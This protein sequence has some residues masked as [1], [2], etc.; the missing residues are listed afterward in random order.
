MQQEHADV[1][2]LFSGG[3]DSLLTALLL[4]EQGLAVRCLHGISPFFGDAAA[5]AG[6]QEE[7]GL[8]F[9]AL[10]VGEDMATMLRDWPAHGFGKVMNPCV[11]CKILLLRRARAYMERVGA[12]AIA[13]G[14]VMGQRPMSQRRDTLNVIEREAGVK[15]LLLRP[16][17]A[18]LLLPTLAEQNGLVDR[19]KLLAISGRGR[20]EQLALAAHFGL[21]HIPT[22]GGGCRLAEKENARRYWPV[23]TRMPQASATDFALAN[24]G[25]QL[26]REGADRAWFWLCV[27]RNQADNAGLAPLWREGDLLLELADAQG[28][29][30]L[31]RNGQHWPDAV[32]RE[33][34]AVTASY[35][36]RAVAER[37][38]QALA[39]RLYTPDGREQGTCS[40]LPA[41]NAQWQTPA[42]D[43]VHTA[44]RAEAK[45]RQGA[46]QNPLQT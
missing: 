16:L 39:V 28:P 15:G 33:A 23:L 21:R 5:L 7:Y 44:I 30:A 6:W 37:P 45:I 38:G 22:P 13:T 8:P 14:E 19:D 46:A 40:T 24:V 18:K 4:R 32:L 12:Q 41:R 26:W 9:D 1:V 11:D 20:T 42:W 10:D 27:G 43:S 2:V 35:A 36:T 31:A 34:C 25:R 17:S 3:L 29:L